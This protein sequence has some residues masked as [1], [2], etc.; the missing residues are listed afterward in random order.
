MRV[1]IARMVHLQKAYQQFSNLAKYHADR[2]ED[3]RRRNP[4]QAEA[5]WGLNLFWLERSERVKFKLTG[6]S[7]ELT[8]Q[9][10][11]SYKEE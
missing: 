1:T 9:I 5:H 3:L 4:E 10:R 8:R 11:R 6:V 7:K 2:V